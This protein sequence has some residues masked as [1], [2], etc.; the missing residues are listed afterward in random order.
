M[1]VVTGFDQ[2]QRQAG[3]TAAEVSNSRGG[4]SKRGLREVNVS[5]GERGWARWLARGEELSGVGGKDGTA[6]GYVAVTVGDCSRVAGPF[7]HG[8][9]AVLEAGDELVAGRVSNFHPGRVMN[10]VYFTAL[11]ETAVWGAELAVAL[12][13][14]T[15]GGEVQDSGAQEDTAG[16]AHVYEVQPTGPF[17]D[18]PN[19][20]NK[21]FPGN[22]TRS[23]RTRYPLRVVGEVRDWAGHDEQTLQKMLWGLRVLREQGRD[24][25][26]D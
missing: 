23:Y 21:K 2:Q 5:E 4:R 1:D 12:A 15:P 14:E 19:V 17:E 24:V 6:D 9:R 11:V 13:G 20:T 7:F 26:E 16:C 3:G 22:V 8:T 25:I 18:D 10:H